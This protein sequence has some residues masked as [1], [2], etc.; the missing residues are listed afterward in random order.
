MPVVLGYTVRGYLPSTRLAAL[1]GALRL[2]E[3]T[4]RELDANIRDAT[5][6][7]LAE[8]EVGFQRRVLEAGLGEAPPM[9]RGVN[10]EVDP[11][12]ADL[13]ELDGPPGGHADA[14]TEMG[15]EMR[16]ARAQGRTSPLKLDELRIEN[17][18]S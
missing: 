15:G 16:C 3:L 5:L 10:A 2:G 17:R 9:I 11:A 4:L 6:T 1:E 13:T 7:M 18:E 12:P 14:L 8:D